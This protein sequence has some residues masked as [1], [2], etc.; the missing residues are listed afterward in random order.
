M[1]QVQSNASLSSV[2]VLDVT[3][4]TQKRVHAHDGNHSSIQNAKNAFETHRGAH[5]IFQRDDLKTI[6]STKIRL[7][8][9][10]GQFYWHAYVN[11][12][13]TCMETNLM[14]FK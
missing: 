7:T 14:H 10:M 3:K 1:R 13:E 12:R 4:E 2:A 9:Q 8:K 6:N 11:V 5:F